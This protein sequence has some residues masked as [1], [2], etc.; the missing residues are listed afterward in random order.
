M[1]A[2]PDKMKVSPGHAEELGQQP[3]KP[4]TGI[5]PVGVA[6]LAADRRDQGLSDGPGAA[7][8]GTNVA[9]CTNVHSATFMQSSPARQ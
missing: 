8:P 6:P 7:S 2:P 3:P 1:A 4:V 5:G 9:L